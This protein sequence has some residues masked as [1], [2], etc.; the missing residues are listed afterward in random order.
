MGLSGSP[1]LGRAAAAAPVLSLLREIL[2]AH[3]DL[4]PGP[5]RALGDR[6]VK[7][8]FSAMLKREPPP[9]RPQWETFMSEW[10]KYLGMLESSGDIET[11]KTDPATSNDATVAIGGKELPAL[12]TGIDRSGHFSEDVLENHLS[13]D[14]RARLARLRQEAAALGK[15]YDNR[16]DVRKEE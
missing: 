5:M 8:E 10:K 1:V 6:Y 2:R 3:R 15:E 7:S 11:L 9:P 14:Q 12:V 13:P 16:P 4:L